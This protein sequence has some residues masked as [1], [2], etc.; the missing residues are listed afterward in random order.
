MTEERPRLSVV[1]PAYNEEGRIVLTVSRILDYLAAHGGSAEVLVVDD[2]STDQTAQIAEELAAQH[3]MLHVLRQP[4]NIGKGAAVRRGVL[5]SGGERVLFMDADLATPIE[6]VERL[7]IYLDQGYD[8][9]IGSR[10]L[11]ESDIRIRQPAFRELMGRT[12]NLM[13]RSL[14]LGGFRDTQCGFK[15]FTREAAQD[16]FERQT[17]DGFAFDVEILLLAKDLGYRVREVPVVWFH[18]PNSKVS[19]FTDASR[20]LADL[21]QLRARRIRRKG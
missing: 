11:A 4:R 16:L 6:E 7:R 8:V 19:P 15:L 18:A 9:V 2:G 13:V 17:L 12:F 14:L 5:E 10:G 20:M 1:I 3:P 21:I